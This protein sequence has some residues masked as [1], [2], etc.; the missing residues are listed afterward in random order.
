MDKYINKDGSV[1]V[2]Y[3][4]ET[5]RKF[6][7]RGG[8]EVSVISTEAMLAKAQRKWTK[9]EDE[10]AKKQDSPAKSSK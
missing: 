10:V 8:V 5:I 1:R 9:V 3:D 7:N 6:V 2:E 4:G